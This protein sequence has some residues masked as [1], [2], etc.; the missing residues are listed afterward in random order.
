MPLWVARMPELPEVETLR[1]MLARTVLGRA[2]SE[3]VSSGAALRQKRMADF[4]AST[5]GRRI[6]GFSRRG[7]YLIVELDGPNAILVHLGMSGTLIRRDDGRNGGLDLRHD[8]L[9]LRLD[10]GSW[11]VYNDPRRFGTVRLVPAGR[12]EQIPELAKLGPE[13][14]TAG[15]DAAYLARVARGR[16][17]AIKNLLMDQ[18]VVAGIG[19]IYAA[20]ILFRAGVRP[21]RC[22]G[23]L[24]RTQLERV[25]G[26]S[27]EVL[28][29]AI[30]SGG[31][32]IR[33][34]RDARGR[35]GNFRL[36]LKVYGRE[37]EPCAACGTPIRNVRLG[38]RASFF[39]PRCQR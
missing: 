10:D 28:R 13:P 6:T 12:L 33:N 25:V 23:G 38:Q 7:K 30:G 14:L 21:T 19:N 35:A 34:Y 18:Q 29:E 27:R 1:R 11:L 32:T 5:R 24:G 16:R 20:E 22:A 15:F 26:A 3:A 2:I 17:V 9:R 36:R 37:G 8:H 31:T 39:C 4:S